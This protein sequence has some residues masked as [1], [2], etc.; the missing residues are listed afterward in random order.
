MAHRYEKNKN[1]EQDLVIDGFENGIA[2]SP[3]KGI[4]NIRNL[5]TSYY[6]GVAY[7]NYKRQ[8]CSGLTSS[9]PQVIDSY[10]ETNYSALL[11]LYSGGN[12]ATGQI[13]YNRFAHSFTQAKF[14][15]SKIGTP[16]GT[17]TAT[18]W[19]G[20]L[21]S[22][23]YNVQA[24]VI[25][26]GASGGTSN[27]GA[28]GAQSSGGGGGAGGYVYSA[29]HPVT[30]GTYSIT[31]GTGGVATDINS[32]GNNGNDSIF[33]TLTASGGGAGGSAFSV[34]GNGGCGG[35]GS[36]TAGGTGSQ[37]GAGGSATDNGY[38]CG[39][40]GG[41]ST[42]DGGSTDGHNDSNYQAPGGVGTSNSISGAGVVYCTGGAGSKQIQNGIDATGNKGNGGS[43]AGYTGMLTYSG[44]GGDGVVIIS[45]PTGAITAT[46]GTITT[47]GGKTI[48]TF[49]TSDNFVVSLVNGPIASIVSSTPV[50]VSTLTGTKALITF[51]FAPTTLTANTYYYITLSYSGGDVSN[52]VEVGYGITNE[53]AN[54]NSVVS[55]D[56]T[57]WT[58]NNTP[59]V[60]NLCFYTLYP[61]T[62]TMTLPVQKATSP[63]GLN[64]VL[65]TSGNIW[66]QSAVN[67]ST[68]NLLGP[69]SGRLGAGAGGLAYWNNYLVVFGA[70]LVE[71]CGDG[72]G[73]SAVIASN[74]NKN[75]YN[76]A[77][78]AIPFTTD[79]ATKQTYLFLTGTFAN[80]PI[81]KVNDP[82]VFT[83]TDSLPAPL[84]TGTTY[85]VVTASHFSGYSYIEV[86][87]TLGG[88]PITLLADGTGT[89][90]INDIS[91]I[92]PVGN[93]TNFVFTS[94]TNIYVGETTFTI[95]SYT[96]LYGQTISGTWAEATG[97][98]N[99]VMPDGNTATATFTNGDASFTT[100]APIVYLEKSVYQVQIL[101]SNAT[102][103]KACVS[104]V[105]GDLY[106][107]NGRS[108][109]RIYVNDTNTDF[110]TSFN[111]ALYSTYSVDYAI[112][113]LLQP[114]DV[115]VDMTDLRNTLVIAGNKDF[116]VWDY[117]KQAPSAPVPVGEQIYSII[118]ILNN[119][120]ILAGQKGN[121]YVSNGYS[122]QLLFKMPDFIA[123]IIDPLWTFG[124]VMFHRSRLFFQALASSTAG[125]NILSGIFSLAVSSTF[126]QQESSAGLV[127][128]AQNSFGLTS[129]SAVSQGLLMDNEPSSSG[130]DSYYSAWGQGT[131]GGIDY[132]NTTLW[133]NSEP[134]IETD[135]IP[136]GTNVQP[137][138]FA[139]AE[140]KLDSP[141]KSGDSISLYA[142]QSL[143]D[144]Y[145][146]IGTTT[147]AVLSDF[148]PN[149]SFQSWQWIQ[150]KIT[151]TCNPTTSSFIRLREVRIR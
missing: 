128:E 134:T 114:N 92:A 12:I 111:P 125:M 150:F 99:I 138:T 14:Y 69:G 38:H 71:F 24:L 23:N 8:L 95:V 142:R 9:T 61:Y 103:F 127:M 108:F 43:G 96:N 131:A 119:L 31:V 145:T 106:F 89:N 41:G 21:Y 93:I 33:D 13:F 88:T 29:S 105:D 97:S 20:Q 91:I 60:N 11:P 102:N 6:P 65:D 130:Q 49:T 68:F 26:G 37:G 45:Y 15:L 146:L 81:L 66:K 67:S 52:A 76:S 39:C 82:I 3:Y 110:S 57:T 17:M 100:T 144:S 22:P 34:G 135:L 16:T 62:A 32:N 77:V 151:M 113:E 44:K 63:A 36:Y 27:G 75:N 117:T 101:N 129:A 85:Y 47:S 148:Y 56:G 84:V 58:V 4:A 121:L 94:A 120:Y 1:G 74:W 139:S 147:T 42:G 140:F 25:G 143:S 10:S 90:T 122:A 83:T 64:Y 141:M 18:L 5:N 123:G 137:R 7:V 73:D 112:Q 19:S 126:L 79:F 46:G 72:S 107:C 28:G 136:I 51:N 124:G 48:H 70:G 53:Y 109:G 87:G 115:C 40:G 116:Y 59:A 30:T 133:S 132:N 98:W 78:S 55:T 104:K 2:V 35:G 118:N 50:N 80:Y 54:N 149:V 86:S